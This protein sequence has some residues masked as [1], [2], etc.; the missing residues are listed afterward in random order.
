MAQDNRP[1]VGVYAEID[2]LLDTRLATLHQ[3]L[4]EL[5]PHVLEHGYL[6]RVEDQFTN[7]SR[8]DFEFFYKN[9]DVNTLREALPTKN[10]RMVKEMC[11]K[12]LMQSTSTPYNSGTKLYINIYPYK[13][14]DVD[15]YYFLQQFGKYLN[16]LVPVEIVNMAPHEVTPLF[17]KKYLGALFIY[18]CSTWLD[19]HSKND[20]FKMN[21]IPDI[22]L[23]IPSIFFG[24]LPTKEQEDSFRTLGMDAFRAFEVS[25]SPIITVSTLNTDMFCADLDEVRKSINDNKHLVT[26]QPE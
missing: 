17:C 5:V 23:Y 6:T 22:V 25:A 18:N 11:L 12:L 8:A 21:Q 14:S 19:T 1:V 4:P 26:S 24:D 16:D 20:A 13:L 2:A 7:I 10:V 15:I 9:R 3:I